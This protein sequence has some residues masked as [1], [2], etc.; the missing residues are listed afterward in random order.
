MPGSH[1]LLMIGS[2]R[3]AIRTIGGAGLFFSYFFKDI[4]MLPVV[5]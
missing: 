1:P 5:G 3:Y 4:L 2:R